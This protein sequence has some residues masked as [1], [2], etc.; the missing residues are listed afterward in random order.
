MHCGPPVSDCLAPEL[1]AH[2]G[3]GEIRT[4]SAEASALQAAMTLPRHR[5]PIS[6][7]VLGIADVRV[8]L[9]GVGL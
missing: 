6:F 7:R 9:T 5:A 4:L 1:Q 3:S 2:G 8:E